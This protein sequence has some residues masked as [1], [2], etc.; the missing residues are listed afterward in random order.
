ARPAG[1]SIADALGPPSIGAGPLRVLSDLLDE[2]VSVREEQ[3]AEAFGVVYARAKLA[4]ELAAASPLA[5]LRAGLVEALPG[6]VLVLSGGNVSAS[7]AATLL[8]G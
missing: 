4:V 3:S 1:V 5:A 6:T 2:A 7:V 8:A